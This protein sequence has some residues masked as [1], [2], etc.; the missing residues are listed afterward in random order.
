M[1]FGILIP[2]T[3]DEQK[4]QER[5]PKTRHTRKELKILPF[6]QNVFMHR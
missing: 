3:L 5:T 1:D 2:I 4:Q 6:W